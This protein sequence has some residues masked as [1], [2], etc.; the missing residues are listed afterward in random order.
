MVY[1]GRKPCGCVVAAISADPDYA[2]WA[3]ADVAK[4]IR[5]GYTV[6]RIPVP[7]L[8]LGCKCPPA[9]PLQPSLLPVGRGAE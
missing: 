1:V 2:K 3:A 8:V 9:A 4:L 6:D 5:D 7:A